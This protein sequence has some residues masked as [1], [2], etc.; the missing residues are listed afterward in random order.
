MDK[1]P[2]AVALAR[3]LGTEIGV[4]SRRGLP[5]PCLPIEAVTA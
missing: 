2:D 1:P 4:V 3:T 5:S